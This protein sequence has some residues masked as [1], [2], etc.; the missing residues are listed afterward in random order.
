VAQLR[1]AQAE[2]KIRL[3]LAR[4]DAL[5]QDCAIRFMLDD[6]VMTGRDV[7]AIERSRLFPEAT[8][9]ELL[10]AHHAG[11]WRAAGLVFARK[12]ID[13][14]ALELVCFVDHV[15]RDP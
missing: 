5:A 1:L 6:G 2:Q 11:I 9:L 7:I 13:Y 10:V 12:I 14:D 3:V 4:V 15:M 8:E